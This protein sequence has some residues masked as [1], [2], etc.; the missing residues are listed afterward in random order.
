MEEEE[1]IG[2]L[3]NLRAPLF[4]HILALEPTL[5]SRLEVWRV[6]VISNSTADS[7]LFIFNRRKERGVIRLTCLW[8]PIS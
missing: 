8:H 4:W 2:R 6:T 7:I 5:S 1:Q 3:A